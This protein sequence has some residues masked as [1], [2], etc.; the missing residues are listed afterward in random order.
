MTRRNPLRLV[1]PAPQSAPEPVRVKKRK[2]KKKPQS[3]PKPFRDYRDRL[4][5]N[6]DYVPWKIGRTQK[7]EGEKEI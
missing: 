2:S 6:P 7:R 3:K 1:E 5:R 4:F